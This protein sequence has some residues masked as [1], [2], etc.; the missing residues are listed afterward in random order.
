[1]IT[2]YQFA[3]A[4]G[5]RCPSP[6]C[7]KLETY[8]RMTALPYQ[9]AANANVLKAPKKKLPYIVDN[10][11]VIADSGFI[12]NYLMETY[13]DSLDAHLSPKQ[14]G[15]ML[16][17]RRLMEEHLYWVAFYFRWVD[18]DNWKI[19]KDVFFED[20]PM[21]MRLVVPTLVRRSAIR[22][23]YGQGIGRHSPDEVFALGCE[24]IT[25]ISDF[26]SDQPYLMGDQPTSLDAIG[27]GMLSNIMRVSIDSRLKSYAL[28]FKNLVAYCDRMHTRYWSN[29]PIPDA[30]AV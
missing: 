12:I 11:H 27:Y 13:G 24:N 19:I 25:A 30:V 28:G 6:V 9:V 5:L 2:L 8:L 3:P 22:D 7:L 26:L 16:G 20:V 29:T 23:L 18:D 14:R 4:L 1:M 17:M 21:P 10:G 15:T